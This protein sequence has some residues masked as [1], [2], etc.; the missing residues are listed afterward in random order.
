MTDKTQAPLPCP[1]CGRPIEGLQEPLTP[2][3]RQTQVFLQAYIGTNGYAPSQREVADSL[4]LK[5]K[6]SAYQRMLELERK[7]YIRRHP[8]RRRS[9][10]ILTE[11]TEL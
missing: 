4:G 5:A 2:A 6:S 3:Q 10:T 1:A 9:I 11:V 7:G 8:K